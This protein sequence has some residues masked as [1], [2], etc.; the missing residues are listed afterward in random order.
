MNR[1]KT[2]VTPPRKKSVKNARFML[3]LCQNS[4][5]GLLMLT[6]KCCYCCIGGEVMLILV[7]AVA[8]TLEISIDL[9]VI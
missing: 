2:P 8:E 1:A 3:V 6:R 4:G 5:S 7:V 9:M